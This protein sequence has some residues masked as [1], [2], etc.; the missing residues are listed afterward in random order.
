MYKCLRIMVVEKTYTGRPKQFSI[1][2][3]I[4]VSREIVVV[5]FANK[6]PFHASLDDCEYTYLHFLIRLQCYLSSVCIKCHKP[7]PTQWQ[8][9]TRVKK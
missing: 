7:T 1:Y 5:N 3:L 4:V 9:K 6:F 8:E 2:I